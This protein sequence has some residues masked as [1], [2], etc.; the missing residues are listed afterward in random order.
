[1]VTFRDDGVGA[2]GG[3][4]AALSSWAS[5]ALLCCVDGE[6]YVD[7]VGCVHRLEGVSCGH[8]CMMGGD[9]GCERDVMVPSRGVGL[10]SLRCKAG[11][12]LHVPTRKVPGTLLGV[13]T[14]GQKRGPPHCHN[15]H[16]IHLS[17]MS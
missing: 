13:G 3:R 14:S 2:R 5:T 7:V 11:E 6:A 4:E 12:L 8:G 17:D 15:L 16:L 9:A 1:M 10:G